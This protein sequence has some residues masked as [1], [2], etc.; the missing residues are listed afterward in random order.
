MADK[1]ERLHWTGPTDGNTVVPGPTPGGLGSLP[2]SDLPR[3][4][5]PVSQE[6]LEWAAER[7]PHHYRAVRAR[8]SDPEP[9]SLDPDAL[10][11]PRTPAPPETPDEQSASRRRR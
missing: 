11:D 8:K 5:F 10:S 7:Y 6:D 3:D 4:D 1:V 2:A 9:A